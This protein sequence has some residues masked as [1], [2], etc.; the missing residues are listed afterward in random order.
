[1]SIIPIGPRDSRMR[2]MTKAIENGMVGALVWGLEHLSARLD[3]NDNS[4]DRFVRACAEGDT[5]RARQIIGVDAELGSKAS[6]RI[7]LE[8][9]LLAAAEAGH[10]DVVV[11]LLE[12]GARARAKQSAPLLAA[13][14]NRHNAVILALLP[15][16][17]IHNGWSWG[18]DDA[19]IEDALAGAHAWAAKVGLTAAL[20]ENA[21][22]DVP[23]PTRKM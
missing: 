15:H 7:S 8:Q 5:D 3:R 18:E 23:R 22:S 17:T 4:P 13:L 6:V 2:R 16:S 11:L 1:M 19:D 21:G 20:G 14:K 12:H 10:V 9:G